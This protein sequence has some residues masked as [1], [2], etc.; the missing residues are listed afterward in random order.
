MS[1]PR[2]NEFDY[3]FET[4]AVPG[5]ADEMYFILGSNIVELLFY[6]LTNRSMRILHSISQYS[7][8]KCASSVMIK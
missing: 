7:L 3:G 2:Q 5:A 1:P 8:K 4:I 6:R